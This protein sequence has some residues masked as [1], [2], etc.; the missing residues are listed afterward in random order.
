VDQPNAF[1][2]TAKLCVYRASLVE[3]EVPHR[4]YFCQPAHN[5]IMV[6]KAASASEEQK[7]RAISELLIPYLGI[8][9]VSAA[10]RFID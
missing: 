6:S 5:R 7:D 8:H 1:R 10:I 2:P 3:S 4:I 9:P